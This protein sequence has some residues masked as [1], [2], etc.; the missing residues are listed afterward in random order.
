MSGAVLRSRAVGA[1]LAL[2]GALLLPPAPADAQDA[3]EDGTCDRAPYEEAFRSARHDDSVRYGLPFRPEIPRLCTQG[4]GGPTHRGRVHYAFD[5]VLP[6]ATPVVAARAGRVVC[7]VDGYGEGSFSE[8]FLDRAN[9]VE[10][11][12]DDG[13]VGDYGHLRAGIAVREGQRVEAGEVL[14]YSGNSGLSNGPHLHF[15]VWGPHPDKGESTLP[16]RFGQPGTAG[17]VPRTGEFYGARPRSRLHL[18]VLV[19]DEKVGDDETVPI[20][21]GES[22][23]VRVFWSRPGRGAL[24]V[25]HDARTAI[26]PV[27]PWTLDVDDDG[28]VHARPSP[29]FGSSPDRDQE[30]GELF[31]LFGKPDRRRYGWRILRFQIGDGGGGEEAGES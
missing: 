20:R 23:S 6:E 22:V 13:T 17:F 27:T 5:F 21:R 4:A 24:D 14:G 3:P 11:Q 15:S 7:V 31:L 26:E 19:D 2:A 29:G 30:L 25:T 8:E 18:A 9:R 1:S 12:H 28:R 16:I 10:I